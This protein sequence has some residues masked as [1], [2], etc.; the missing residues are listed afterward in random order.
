MVVR[1]DSADRGGPALATGHA[2]GSFVAE[3][4][5]VADTLL[6]GSYTCTHDTHGRWPMVAPGGGV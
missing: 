5:N 2:C 4:M 1:G 6:H 3:H